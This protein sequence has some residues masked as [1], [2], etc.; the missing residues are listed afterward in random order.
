MTINIY[1]YLNYRLYIFKWNKIY[2]KLN[3]FNSFY[4][5]K[6]IFIITLMDKDTDKVK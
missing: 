6:K 5:M 3:N 1:F 2:L 4:N